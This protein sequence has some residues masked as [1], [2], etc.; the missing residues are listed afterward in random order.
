[1]AGPVDPLAN[2][3]P[4]AQSLRNRGLQW[5]TDTMVAKVP[6]PYPGSGRLV[7][8]ANVHLTGLMAYLT[9][10]VFQFRELRYKLLNDDG[11]EPG[12]FPFW[13]LY[14]SVMHLTA[15]LF[16]ENI[17]TV[18]HER[19]ICHGT[20]SRDSVPVDLRAIANTALMTIEGE[21]DDIAAPGQTR[22]AHR[23]CLRIPDRMRNHVLVRGAGHFSLFHGDRCR[24]TVLPEICGFLHRVG[25]R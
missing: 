13:K 19:A 14:A 9:R 6:A 2:P 24:N 22:A 15:E 16:L 1:M 11:A 4:V 10:H 25:G 3:T 8:R 20:L 7:H 17:Q 21:H 12:R 23:L 18:F 5:F